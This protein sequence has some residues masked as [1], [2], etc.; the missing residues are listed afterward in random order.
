MAAQENNM[1][2]TEWMTDRIALL[3]ALA[4]CGM[5]ALGGCGP[6]NANALLPGTYDGELACSV[7][8]VDPEGAEG[9]EEFTLAMT[10]VVD[11]DGNLTVNDEPIIVGGS[12]TRS[13]PNAD[14]AFE[15]LTLSRD[16]GR[17][18]VTYAP[19]PTLTGITVT[20][21]LAEEY[22]R[23]GAGITVSGRTDLVVTDISGDSTFLIECTGTLP[24]Q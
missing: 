19:R 9:T 4:T 23:A 20:G 21:E 8:G 5:L 1:F 3:A 2:D 22:E 16:A 13:L 11:T 12:A 15:V 7:T 6:V 18:S 10:L 17:V 24:Q 14:L